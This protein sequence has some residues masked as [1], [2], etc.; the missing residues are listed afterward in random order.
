MIQFAKKYGNL[1]IINKRLHPTNSR[2]T[3]VAVSDAPVKLC[4]VGIERV[5]TT[6]GEDPGT[7]IGVGVSDVKRHNGRHDEAVVTRT[8]VVVVRTVMFCS[9][10]IGDSVVRYN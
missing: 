6:V 5:D 2:D 4:D 8:R 9:K 1:F 10:A 3:H 7:A